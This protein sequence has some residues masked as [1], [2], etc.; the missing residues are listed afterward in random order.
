MMEPHFTRTN[1]AGT[2]SPMCCTW[3]LLQE[4]DTLTL[5]AKS[6]TPTMIRCVCFCLERKEKLRQ[7]ANVSNV[8]CFR[9]L[10]ITT[11][12]SRV[13]FASSPILLR[14]SSSSLGRVMGVFMLQHW[15]CLWQQERLKSTSRWGT[16]GG[17]ICINYCISVA[18]HGGDQ[19]VT[20][21]ETQV[22]LT[23]W[24]WLLN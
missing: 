6:T 14:M 4:W 12:P 3:N 20:A 17:S 1:S 9:L 18:Q 23:V 11:K 19:P 10:K 24:S 13:S 5:M 8:L 16:A 21:E 22:A 15:A 2:G 7:A